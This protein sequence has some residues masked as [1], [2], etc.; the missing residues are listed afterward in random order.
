ML[1]KIHRIFYVT[2]SYNINVA[3]G[4]L[5]QYCVADDKTREHQ[6]NFSQHKLIKMI[7]IVCCVRYRLGP[8]NVRRGSA[9]SRHI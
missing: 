1:I 3:I 4:V 2:N 9:S 6:L 5:H 8:E 7:L